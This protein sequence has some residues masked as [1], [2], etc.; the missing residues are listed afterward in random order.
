MANEQVVSTVNF[1]LH[2]IQYKVSY[3]TALSLFREI[4]IDHK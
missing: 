2:T 4:L 1:F 3:P